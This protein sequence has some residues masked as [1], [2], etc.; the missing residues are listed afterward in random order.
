MITSENFAEG[1]NYQWVHQLSSCG[2]TDVTANDL[3]LQIMYSCAK[4]KDT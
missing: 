1:L 3:E 2:L 4:S